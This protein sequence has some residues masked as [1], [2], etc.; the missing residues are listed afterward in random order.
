M[1]TKILL[2]FALIAFASCNPSDSSSDQ[3]RMDNQAAY[4]AIKT[5]EEWTLL[6][7]GDGPSGVYYR[8]LTAP[9]TELGDEYPLETASVVVNYAGRFYND[10]VFDSGART[11]FAVNAVVRGFGFALQQMRVGQKWDV[12]I[13]YYLGYGVVGNVSYYTGQI[14]IQGYTTLF[15]EI[16]LLKIDQYPK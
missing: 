4:D 3:W 10:N 9:E 11:A 12:C 13:P 7:T 5:N 8:D 2:F 6:E 16:E 15:F 14:S 1:K